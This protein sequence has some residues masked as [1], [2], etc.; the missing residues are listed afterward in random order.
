MLPSVG[1]KNEPLVNISSSGSYTIVQHIEIAL[2]WSVRNPIFDIMSQ[3]FKKK[4]NR[5]WYELKGRFV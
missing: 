5:G 2:R 4:R 1:S 3:E